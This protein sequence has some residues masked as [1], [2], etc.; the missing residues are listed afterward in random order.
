MLASSLRSHLAASISV[1]VAL[2]PAVLMAPKRKY[3][4]V[5]AGYR[6]GIYESWAECELQVKGFKGQNYKS[7]QSKTEA[8]QYLEEEGSKRVT[9]VAK[10][11]LQKSLLHNA[12]STKLKESQVALANN[13]FK[14]YALQNSSSVLEMAP[15]DYEELVVPS[16]TEPD[17]NHL[18]EAEALRPPAHLTGDLASVSDVNV[19]YQL[20]YDGASKGNP[21]V[22]GAGALLRHPDGTVV[23]EISVGLG[24]ATNNVAEYRG[25]IAGMRRALDLGI[26]RIQVQGDSKLVTMQV[27][28]K[29][30]II[31][32]SLAILCREAT[33]LLKNFKDFQIRHVD[34][35]YNSSADALANKGVSLPEEKFSSSFSVVKK[36]M[37]NLVN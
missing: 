10:V 22:A 6:P 8:E 2:S 37:G 13:P 20:E 1:T 17:P 30:K 25:L 9:K 26:Q 14:K 28:G 36:L 31:N 5:A 32:P 23:S 16:N 12:I 35:E 27:R 24:K 11:A 33:E 19:M 15:A 7:F 4:A 29:W 34:R 18:T 21:G 3:Y